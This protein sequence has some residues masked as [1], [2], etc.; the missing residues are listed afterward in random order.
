MP[1]MNRTF[2]L[3]GQCSCA[4]RNDWF[5][6]GGIYYILNDSFVHVLPGFNVA[7]SS[8]QTFECFYDLTRIGNLLSYVAG[9]FLLEVPQ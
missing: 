4:T 9:I 7:C 3:Y 6:L 2:Q 8:L 1:H 5:Q